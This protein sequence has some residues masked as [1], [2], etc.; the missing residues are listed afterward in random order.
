MLIICDK[1]LLHPG[2]T[3]PLFLRKI[4]INFLKKSISYCQR[5][6][7]WINFNAVIPRLDHGIQ[8]KILKL[9]IL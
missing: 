8:F 2:I 1:G 9:L 4:L 3:L 5:T 6:A 7:A